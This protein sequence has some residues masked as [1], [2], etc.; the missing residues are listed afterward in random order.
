MLNFT[1]TS[2]YFALPA[3]IANMAPVFFRPYL[4]FLYKP[5]DGGK[6]WNGKPVLGSHKTWGGFAAGIFAAIIIVFIQKILYQYNIFSKISYINYQKESVILVG[7]L[8]GFGALFGDSIKSLIKRRLNI[9]SGDRFFPWDQLDMLLGA[10][11]LISL[12]K[13][14]SLQM[15]I[16]YIGFTLVAHPLINIIGYK[17]GFKEVPW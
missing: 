17:L 15:W 16:F 10:G 2:I 7:F 5:V 11:I 6:K 3:M 13:P 9:K 14:L 12:I 1:L 4:K 8:F